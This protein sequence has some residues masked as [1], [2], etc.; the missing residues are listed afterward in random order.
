MKPSEKGWLKDYLEF[1][2][3][4]LVNLTSEAARKGSHPEHSLYRIVQPTG[5]M[6]GQSVGALG[7]LDHPNQ[8][9]WGEK[10]KMKILLAERPTFQKAFSAPKEYPTCRSTPSCKVDAAFVLR[11]SRMARMATL[12]MLT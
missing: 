12:A 10:D 3:D 2:K 11:P 9:H 6:Y 8:Q 4:L 7:A 1:R 5:L